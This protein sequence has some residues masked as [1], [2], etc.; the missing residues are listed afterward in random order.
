VDG[1]LS[2]SGNVA[3]TA[4]SYPVGGKVVIGAASSFGAGSSL[5]SFNG[6]IDSARISSGERYVG[7]SFVP[8]TY[9]ASDANTLGLWQFSESSGSST[10]D[11]SGNGHIG[12]ISGAT[13]S[14]T[15]AP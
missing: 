2:S 5:L 13:W 10:A 6:S 12:T 7:S 8:A 3:G 1:I 14:A 11:G 15:C 4:A 9:L